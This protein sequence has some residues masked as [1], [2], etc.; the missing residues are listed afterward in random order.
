MNPTAELAPP[1]AALGSARD[2]RARLPASRSRPLLVSLYAALLG[3]AGLLG[4]AARRRAM[5][6]TVRSVPAAVAFAGSALLAMRAFVG[7]G[8]GARQAAASAVLVST[9]AGV[10]WR[11]AALARQGRR[12][13]ARDELELGSL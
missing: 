12:A 5:R 13:G 6:F 2:M 1:R 8:R 7:P 10:A 4:P 11:R 9:L 3:E